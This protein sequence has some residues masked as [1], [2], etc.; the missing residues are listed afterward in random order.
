QTKEG[1]EGTAELTIKVGQK[2][3]PL[4]IVNNDSFCN[5][6]L[7]FI[8]N[9]TNLEEPKINSINWHVY[10][11]DNYFN[12][13]SLYKE[14][15]FQNS[16]D[17]DEN[18]R[19]T[20]KKE[21]NWYNVA[22]ITEHNGCFDTTIENHA[23]FVKD[24]LA[25]IEDEEFFPCHSDYAKFYNES[26]GADSIIWHVY[27][28]KAGHFSSEEDT[29]RIS[30]ASHGNSTVHLYAFN[31][32]TECVDFE[33]RE[34]KFSDDFEAD[35]SF[36]GDPC[37]PANITFNVDLDVD[38]TYYTYSANWTINESPGGSD[39]S[40]YR[41]FDNP[42]LHNVFLRVTQDETGC[43][44]TISKKVKITGPSVDGS[45]DFSATCPP[46]PIT[47]TTNSDPSL[48][49]TL[50]WEIEGRQIPVSSSGSMVDTLFMPGQDTANHTIVRLIGIDSN[51]C[52]GVQSFPVKVEGPATAYIKTRRIGRCTGQDFI[53]NGEVPG[54]DVDDFTYFWDFGNDSTSTSRISSM[55]YK[56]VGVYN[57]KLTI[58]E[59]NG[60]KSTFTET[61]DINKER[62]NAEFN[63][64]SIATDCPPLFVQFKNYSTSPNRR[65]NKFFWDFGD[66]TTSIEEN[67]SKLYLKAG[68]YTVKLNVIDEWG[69]EDS[70]IYTDF[71]IVNG[72]EGEYDFDKKLGCVPL[73]VNFTSTTKRANYFEWDMGDGNVIKNVADYT[74]VYDIPGRFIP[75]LILS[76][77]FG[78]SYTLPPIDTIYVDPYPEPDFSNNIT[79]VDNPVSFLGINKNGLI[80][81]EFM[82]EMYHSNGIDTLYGMRTTYTFKGQISPRVKLTITSENGCSNSITKNI[83]LYSLENKFTSANPNNCVGTTITLKDLTTSDT[84]I[85]FTKW[86]V[87]GIEYHEPNP[88]FLASKIGQV[89]ITLIH[90][91][92]LGCRDTLNDFNVVIGDSIKPLDLDMLRVT[93]ND[94][95][96]VQLDY[97]ESNLVDFKSY[98]LYK[99]INS[100][101][102]KIGEVTDRKQTSFFSSGNN[103]LDQ[104]YCFKVEVRNACGLL[105]DTL[106]H[107]EHCTIETDATGGQNHN[108][109]SWS[110]Y[111][112][113]DS[114]EWYNIYRKIANTG[115]AMDHIGT[116]P[117]DS[118][119][120]IDSLLYCNTKYAYKI[121]GTEESGN[122][123]VSFSDTAEAMPQWSY[124]PPPNK[125]VRATVEDD[126]E[127]L[128]EW[129]SVRNSLIPISNYVLEKSMNGH[130]YFKLVQ[131]DN[132]TFSYLDKEVKVD[133]YS[134]FYRTYAIDE[135]DDTTDFWNFGKTILLD[136]TVAD[137]QRP[138]LD[139]SHYEGWTEDITYYSVEIK[140]PDN[141]FTEI[142]TFYDKDT[143]L[144]D[145]VTDLNQ[146]PDYCYRIVA[147]KDLVPGESQVFS[148]S[149][150][151][152]SPVRSKIYYPNAFTPNND[153]L[154]DFYVT[155]SQY[156][157]EYKIMIFTRWGE[158]VFES[159]DL[160]E[161]WDG[162]Y[163]GEEA[164][165][166]AFAVV[167]IST[168][169]DGIR[170]VHKG[171]ITLVR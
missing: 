109:V 146:R 86:I 143:S 37:S 12:Q 78:C 25:L 154:N 58:T 4:F 113:W 155:P 158:K 15:P 51:G 54:F 118:L 130:D 83:K 142:S 19:D 165:M 159:Y 81:K 67:P 148:R 70:V 133:D 21:S 152:C 72:P 13:D 112:G 101:F 150:E 9:T 156:I 10:D 160:N 166:D 24:P 50:Y 29:V 40:L 3:H 92:I 53:F 170:R 34:V 47:L 64:D 55:T 88:Q 45:V 122:Q 57:V 16:H 110:P 76:D 95:Q 1:C 41:R 145:M 87:D 128:I 43:S 141:S 38:T 18:Y 108:L 116:V 6:D 140:N 162:T 71:V 14:A 66:G 68:K 127:I 79:C 22:L 144:I 136:A 65:I 98:V 147:Y 100:L 99:E 151:D 139:W 17:Y 62:I 73:T 61:I 169:V 121:E 104:S 31:F 36:S 117:G 32:E 157:K 106:T 90:Q 138:K 105:S 111:I 28:S 161:H 84:T 8:A 115:A 42:G 96:T 35:F 93:V 153:N 123:Q 137:D 2:T 48:Y 33:M 26:V 132:E 163:Q 46:L 107:L 129:D 44:D 56:T 171:T 59:K 103:T 126:I 164:Q 124:K 75:L 91:N 125:L 69:C 77:T 63:A 20:L 131:T 5:Q 82:W 11:D 149:N 97:K 39:F 52:T 7:L 49:D 102:Q 114:V 85:T 89:D 168:G 27:T 30:R 167:V 60:C 135:C 94:N 74:H 120:Y 134:Y 119:K 80:P 23:F